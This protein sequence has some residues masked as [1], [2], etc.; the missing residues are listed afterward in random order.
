MIPRLGRRFVLNQI[1]IYTAADKAMNDHDP[2]VTLSLLCFVP[3]NIPRDSNNEAADRYYLYE[4]F[5]TQSFCLTYRVITVTA[6]VTLLLNRRNEC[7]EED[8]FGLAG[9]ADGLRLTVA[10]DLKRAGG[11]GVLDAVV[12]HDPC[13]GDAVVEI[14]IALMGVIA[15]AGAGL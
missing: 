3:C 11:E 9:V 2:H 8:E 7:A 1:L 5:S 14:F 4:A 10:C 6:P 12:D 15:D 13:A